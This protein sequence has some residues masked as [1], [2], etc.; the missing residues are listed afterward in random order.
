MDQNPA[1]A[2]GRSGERGSR[3]RRKEAHCHILSS[4]GA[5]SNGQVNFR[6]GVQEDRV[7]RDISQ[8]RVTIKVRP[9]GT[10]LMGKKENPIR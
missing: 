2:A 6:K 8:T 10:N 3:P 7:Q 9:I 1:A 5:E 4:P